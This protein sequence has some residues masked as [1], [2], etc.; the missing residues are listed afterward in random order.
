MSA[1]EPT[2]QAVHVVVGAGPLGTHVAA[3]LLRQG[4]AVRMVTRSGRGL[5]GAELVAAD[6]SHAEAAR[7]FCSG[8]VAVYACAQ[9]P[10][11]RWVDDFPPLQRALLEGARSA[12]AVYVAAENLYPYGEVHGPISED[13]PF[14]ATTRKGRLRAELAREVHD[15]HQQGSVCTV[16]GRAS[17]FYGPLVLASAVGERF[18]GPIVTGRDVRVMGDPDAP[19]TYTS[20]GDFARALVVLATDD[21][22]WGSAWHVPSAPAITTR[23]LA[24]LGYQAAGTS[25]RVKPLSRTALRAAGLFV[26]AARE[27]VEMLYEFEQ[28]FVMS[29][30]RFTAT[31]GDAPTPH[32]QVVDDT[33]RWWRDQAMVAA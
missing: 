30:E 6:A 9:P 25:G 29:H 4:R 7:R 33:V 26:P 20:V 18:F 2:A 24:E 13:L 1:R 32:E 21:R 10:Y 15:I 31:F 3:E 19:H 16:A 23:R 28:P 14:R 8:A 12:G 5:A 27:L 11:H 22:A 17:D